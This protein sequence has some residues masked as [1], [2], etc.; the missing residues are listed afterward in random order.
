MTREA[1]E[2]LTPGTRL[3]GGGVFVCNAGSEGAWVVWPDADT[4][5]DYRPSMEAVCWDEIELPA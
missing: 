3:A 2:K 1:G 5:D 4:N